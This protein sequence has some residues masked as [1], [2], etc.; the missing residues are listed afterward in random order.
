[1][2]KQKL[3]LFKEKFNS[4]P[5]LDSFW[6]FSFAFPEVNKKYQISLGEGLT[7]TKKSIRIGPNLGLNDL[8][9][10]DET[11]NPTNSFKDRAAALLISDARSKGFHKVVCASNG[12]QGASISAYTSLEGMKCVNIIPEEID[13]GKKAQ[14]MV[15]N[16]KIIVKGDIIDDAIGYALKEKYKK[17]Y[18]QCTPEYNPL[19]I[20]G[21][22]TIAF[23]IY[24]DVG[25]PDWIIVPMGNGGCLVSLWKGFTELK[26]TGLIKRY[27]KLVGVQ[28]KSCS[29]IVNAYLNR[30]DT[31]IHKKKE[32][33]SKASSV[34]VKKPF[35]QSLCLKAIKETK[36]T[37]LAIP[38]NLMISAISELARYEGIFAEPASALTISALNLLIQEHGMKKGDLTIC[39][40]TGSGLK[41][42]YVLEAI[43]SRAKTAGMGGI[44][45]TKL[46][47]LSQI[48][49]SREKGI[50]GTRLKEII[51]SI[52]LPAIYQHLKEL[53]AKNLIRRKKKGKKVIYFITEEG[54]KVLEAME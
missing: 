5:P 8:F 28:T 27:P 1:M 37:A 33:K 19:T 23:E 34:L 22:K 4:F 54:T 43:S 18:Y 26:N 51:G 12:N 7:A 3:D 31:K 32:F 50:H 46:K 9:F 15:Y 45:S 36:G 49:I 25:I 47:I 40:I 24:L 17:D 21:Q 35:Y 10:K 29:P 16:S 11:H 52:S 48:S 39:V 6:D 20:E 2:I 41:A 30:N 42:P 13:I 14:M 38:E 44:L 53:E